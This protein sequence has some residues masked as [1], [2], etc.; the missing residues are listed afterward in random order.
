M[1]VAPIAVAGTNDGI[2]TAIRPPLNLQ[3]RMQHQPYG[4]TPGLHLTND[5]IDEKR[6][7][8]VEDFQN[9]K[10]DGA[11]PHRAHSDFRLTGRSRFHPAERGG[12][13]FP[14]QSRAERLGRICW[15]IREKKIS[16]G[17]DRRTH[18]GSILGQGSTLQ[19][20]LTK[21]RLSCKVRWPVEVD[22]PRPARPCAS[23]APAAPFFEHRC[24]ART[25]F[26]L[27]SHAA[28]PSNVRCQTV[29][30]ADP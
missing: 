22:Y 13:K 8:V 20:L 21:Q 4:K 3:D 19:C 9:S 18:G 12:C 2:E 7:I 14:T 16:Q 1:A 26:F 6:H 15:Q 17:H 11:V 23:N 10:R 30:E 27:A 29:Q 28:N 25:L 24:G 5:A